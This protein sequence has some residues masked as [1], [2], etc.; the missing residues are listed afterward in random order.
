MI[1]VLASNVPTIFPSDQL[2]DLIDN[3][4]IQVFQGLLE[5]VS[6]VI[7]VKR[8]VHYCFPSEDNLARTNFFFT[9]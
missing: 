5:Q 6:G 3:G 9:Q 1:N 7:W 4:L 8:R 2:I